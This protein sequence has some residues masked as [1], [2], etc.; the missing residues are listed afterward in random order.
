MVTFGIHLAHPGPHPGKYKYIVQD[1][2]ENMNTTQDALS[3]KWYNVYSFALMIKLPGLQNGFI[4]NLVIHLQPVVIQFFHVQCM[5]APTCPLAFITKSSS[6]NFCWHLEQWMPTSLH[7][8]AVQ[9][10]MVWNY[11]V[12]LQQ[13]HVY[14]SSHC[15]HMHM[16]AWVE[17]I[18]R[19]SNAMLGSTCTFH[20]FA[21]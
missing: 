8:G 7:V 13:L 9:M 16:H 5:S 14:I 10:G 19:S 12:L 4:A 11:L 21:V 6:N 1:I 18:I 15:S 17:C 2:L 3:G 20:C